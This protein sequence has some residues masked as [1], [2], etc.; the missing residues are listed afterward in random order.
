MSACVS[1]VAARWFPV[2]EQ[3]CLTGAQGAGMALGVAIG[4]LAM[5]AA[6]ARCHGD[7]RAAMTWMVIAPLLYLAFSLGTLARAEH[8]QPSA[9]KLLPE[10]AS[11]SPF[12]LALRPAGILRRHRQHVRICLDYAGLQCLGADLLG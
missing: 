9:E 10:E 3:G 7:W 5:P 11:A 1:V 12:G 2:E 8:P 4:L 6:L